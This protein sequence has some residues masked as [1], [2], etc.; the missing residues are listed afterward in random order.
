MG[1]SGPVLRARP[2]AAR[3]AG[4]RRRHPRHERREGRP[5]AGWRSTEAASTGRACLGFSRLHLVFSRRME[6]IGCRA[7]PV[8][9]EKAAT[10][11]G[12]AD[13]VGIRRAVIHAAEDAIGVFV[14]VWYVAPAISWF[15]LRV[16]RALVDSRARDTRPTDALRSASAG[17]ALCGCAAQGEADAGRAVPTC[18]FGAG[19]SLV[20]ALRAGGGQLDANFGANDRTLLGARHAPTTEACARFAVGFV[21]ADVARWDPAV[22]RTTRRVPRANLSDV[23]RVP[24]RAAHGVCWGDVALLGATRRWVVE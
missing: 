14:S 19:R 8:H 17:N 4:K 16:V 20:Q 7:H 11:W 22:P 10:A 15:G 13:F 1:C 3:A 21:D 5:A 6:G 23:T 9:L 12:G 2:R 18:G 24:R